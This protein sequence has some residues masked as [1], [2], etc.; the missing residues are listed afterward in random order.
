MKASI[1]NEL[2]EVL[3]DMT[4][5]T[6]GPEQAKALKDF[7]AYLNKKGLLKKSGAI[8]DQYQKL[9]NKKHDIVVAVVTLTARLPDKEKKELAEALKK[10]YSA[11]V[12]NIEE[13]VDMRLIG[14]M[15][16]RIGDEV[17]DSSIQNS[18]DQLQAQLLK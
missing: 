15:K 3:L 7:A 18:L 8:M 9:Y 5:G 12:V 6:S 14:G 13:R 17:Y 1:I 11:K 4:E 10:K 2:A 16:V